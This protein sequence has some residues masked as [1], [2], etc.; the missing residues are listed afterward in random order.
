MALL[1]FPFGQQALQMYSPL[2]KDASALASPS[3]AGRSLNAV[4][5]CSSWSAPSHEREEDQ[6]AAISWA[7]GPEWRH[8][9]DMLG[10]LEPD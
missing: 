9:E 8:P 4:W 6:K 2:I 3:K 5:K 7:L 1:G 10:I